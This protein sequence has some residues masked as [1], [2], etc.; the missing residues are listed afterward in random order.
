MSCSSYL[1]AIPFPGILIASF[2]GFA[3]GYFV[4]Y[5]TEKAKEAKMTQPIPSTGRHW[6]S[7]YETVAPALVVFCI[8]CSMFASVGVFF[9]SRVNA[10][11][12]ARRTADNTR[13]IRCFDKFATDLSGSLPAVRAAS[14]V[15][16]EAL[17]NVLIG[18]DEHLGLGLLI[19]RAQKGIK[20]D[21]KKDLA[22][23]AKTFAEFQKA[24]DHLLKVQKDNPY[25]AA[26]SKF[27]DL[28]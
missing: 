6:R 8:V 1:D 23:L 15:R 20:G 4:R 27:C 18:N 5:L 13:F 9:Q 3:A 21:P 28:P 17:A 11:Q 24:D 16:N 26:P 2:V 19:Y 25:P 22:A 12:D 14:Q 10:E 7:L